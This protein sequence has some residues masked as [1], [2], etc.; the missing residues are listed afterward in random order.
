MFLV[1]RRGG[2][3][4]PGAGGVGGGACSWCCY[5]LG[6]KEHLGFLHK[7]SRAIEGSFFVT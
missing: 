6:Y 5:L 1:L 7:E 3:D 4:V 2:G